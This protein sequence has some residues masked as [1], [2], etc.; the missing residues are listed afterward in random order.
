MSGLCEQLDPTKWAEL[1]KNIE[2]VIFDA[3]GV[4]WLGVDAVPGSPA[5]VERLAAMGKQ[6]II[7]TNNSTKSRVDYEEKCQKLGIKSVKKENIVNPPVLC[8]ELLQRSALTKRK[9]YLIGIQG[10]RDELAKTGFQYVGDG[11][12]HFEN[13][14]ETEFLYDVALD[15]EVGAVIVGYDNH[16]NYVKLM[17]AANYLR[18]P[19]CLFIAS[20]EDSTFPGPNKDVTI[21]GTGAL[22]AAVKVAAQRE[23]LV[24]GKPH[25][26][27]Y[28]Y[29]RAHWN[30][31]P[32]KTLMVG[33][34]CDTDIKFGIDNGM[35]TMLVLSGVHTLDDVEKYRKEDR[36][37][38][39]PDFYAGKLGDLL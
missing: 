31:D 20:N 7:V 24:M 16:F 5:V 14:S 30:I 4:L 6:I 19:K 28:N 34:R 12:D 36:K 21:P 35:K 10:L 29:I 9:I 25:I 32:T 1:L 39:L 37:D 8:S 27:T 38:L 2:T 33:D 11:P 23:P 18:D 22:V 3:D 13:Y 26:A 17:K 15:P